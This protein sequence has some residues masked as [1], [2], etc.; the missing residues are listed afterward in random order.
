MAEDIKVYFESD[1]ESRM[2]D[3]HP[4]GLGKPEDVAFAIAYF[5]SDASRWVTGT[6]LSVDGGYVAQ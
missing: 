6:I 3:M 1:H 4:L 5:M 2:S